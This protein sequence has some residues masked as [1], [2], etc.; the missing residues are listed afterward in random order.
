MEE[1]D[2]KKARPASARSLKAAIQHAR[3]IQ[4]DR[5]DA[6]AD[7]READIARLEILADELQ[8][9][10]DELPDNADQFECTIVP[11]ERPRLWV[12]MLA[13]VAMSRDRHIYRFIKTT[14]MGRS[15]LFEGREVKAVAD[16]VTEYIA[17]RM[18]E[19]EKAFEG[20]TDSMPVQARNDGGGGKLFA[21]V[22][23][24]LLGVA[25]FAGARWL[26]LAGLI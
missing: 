23:G 18:I 10:I 21:F 25:V 22:L 1:P 13:Y 4:A 12:D 9:V 6:M 16:H 17:H 5:S 11:G 2:N 26:T 8:P 19:R 7:L 14:R 24:V 3:L 20:D 15:V